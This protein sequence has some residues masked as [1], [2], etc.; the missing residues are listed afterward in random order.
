MSQLKRLLAA[1]QSTT[2]RRV[3]MPPSVSDLINGKAKVLDESK[4]TE[5]VKV[6]FYNDCSP[7]RKRSSKADSVVF[8]AFRKEDIFESR[9]GETT[10]RMHPVARA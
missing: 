1:M 4:F 10:R 9:G 6:Q 2:V 3:I 8:I 5:L 7:K